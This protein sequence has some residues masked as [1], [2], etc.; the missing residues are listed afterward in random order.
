MNEN[1]VT[2]KYD[3]GIYNDYV[4]SN[5]GVIKNK[6]TGKL[7]S[8]YKQHNKHG[9][10][11]K[12][13]IWR[14]GE[15]LG[16]HICI[17][18]AVLYSFNQPIHKHARISYKDDN[19]FNVS[20]KNISANPKSK[21]FKKREKTDISHI[22]NYKDEEFKPLIYNN[23]NYNN[24]LVSNYGR[25]Y[26]IL[27]KRFVNL[28]E[29]SNVYNHNTALFCYIN[30][31]G[32]QKPKK[33]Y[34]A[35]IVLNTFKPDLYNKLNLNDYVIKYLDGNRKNNHID[36]LDVVHTYNYIKKKNQ[37]ERINRQNMQIM[38]YYADEKW[39]PINKYNGHKLEF[40]RYEVSNYG[41]LYDTKL[42][43][44]LVMQ[45]DWDSR[46]KD[47]VWY[48]YRVRAGNK[49]CSMSA[50]KL[51]ATAFI[52]RTKYTSGSKNIYFI[53]GNPAN[54]CA[55]N[56][57]WAYNKRYYKEIYSPKYNKTIKLA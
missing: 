57:R 4:I 6:D 19:H 54:I 34:V 10:T 35:K 13:I 8:Y 48:K 17:A 56:I 43:K 5:L 12:T 20:L 26:N 40:N 31:G 32:K 41:R 22:K 2:L 7:L 11:L 18:N 39:K 16:K 44:M 33:I 23:I 15:N 46:G 52:K 45:P 28:S 14:D 25:I 53:D 49:S 36:N 29:H 9:I 42:N 21:K 47:V 30:V 3:D 55:D 24:Y 50:G 27:Q 37:S 1:W 51:V 38:I